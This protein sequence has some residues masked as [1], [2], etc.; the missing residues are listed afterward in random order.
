MDQTPEFDTTYDPVVSHQKVWKK[1]EF[2]TTYDPIV[3][4]QKV[5]KKLRVSVQGV[6]SLWGT[7]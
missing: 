4:H 2:D 1:T 6:E 5:W 3:S 7:V